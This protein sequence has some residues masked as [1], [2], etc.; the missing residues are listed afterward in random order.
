[1][2]AGFLSVHL[3][4]YFLI[5]SYMKQLSK[6]V[7]YYGDFSMLLS[8]RGNN[9]QKNRGDSFYRYHC[10]LHTHKDVADSKFENVK[11]DHSRTYSCSAPW[12]KGDSPMNTRR[13]FNVWCALSILRVDTC[14]A[15]IRRLYNVQPLEGA[16]LFADSTLSTQEAAQHSQ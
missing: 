12:F 1:M 4:K 5:W 9:S 6:Y 2:Q 8:T 14:M 16:W 10:T 11:A 3:K 7:I 15:S 13:F